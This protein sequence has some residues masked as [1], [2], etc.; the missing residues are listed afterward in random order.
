[1]E[2]WYVVVLTV[3]RFPLVIS[4]EIAKYEELAKER[5]VWCL[6]NIGFPK[7]DWKFDY[8]DNKLTYYFKHS[9]DATMFSLKWA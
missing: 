5:D 7:M 2:D 8:T 3:P 6:H 1:M 9:H 4:E